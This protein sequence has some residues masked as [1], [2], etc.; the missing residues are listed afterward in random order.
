MFTFGSDKQKN[1]TSGATYTLDLSNAKVVDPITGDLSSQSITDYAKKYG[2]K[3]TGTRKLTESVWYEVAIKGGD[4]FPQRVWNICDPFYKDGNALDK[5]YDRGGDDELIDAPGLYFVT[6]EM[7]GAGTSEIPEFWKKDKTINGVAYESENGDVFG[8]FAIKCGKANVKT[9]LAKVSMTVTSI[10]GKKKTFKSQSVNVAKDCD[11]MIIEWD[12]AFI[13]LCPRDDEGTLYGVG[14]GAI[15][16]DGNGEFDLGIGG[17]EIIIGGAMDK[18]ASFNFEAIEDVINEALDNDSVMTSAYTTEGEEVSTY[19]PFEFT[20]S[21]KRWTLAK[22]ASI[23]WKKSPANAT[24]PGDWIINTSKGKTNIPGLKLTYN[25]RTGF[26]KGSF[27]IYTNGGK[28]H[29]A[30]VN[31]L[32]VD[33][34]GYGQATIKKLGVTWPVTIE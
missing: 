30:T 32:V 33:G 4:K 15:D 27:N 23:R 5:I 34:I 14:D 19:Q 2:V 8:T 17:N 22:A 10:F 18:V 28:K 29:S 11:D 25:A 24:H 3:L 31:G 1:V 6:K 16:W 26:F 12:G 13:N 21:S 9:G 20:M 7:T